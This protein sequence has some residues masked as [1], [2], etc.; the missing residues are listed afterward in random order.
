MDKW[1]YRRVQLLIMAL[2]VGAGAGAAVSFFCGWSKSIGGLTGGMVGLSLLWLWDLRNAAKVMHWLGDESAKVNLPIVFSNP[3]L[4][5]ELFRRAVR[6]LRMRDKQIHYERE[7]LQL[8]LSALQIAP[9]G[10]IL[11]DQHNRVVWGNLSASKFL[12]LV[13]P[14]DYQQQITNL[15]RQ[16]E[17]V[18][19]FDHLQTSAP[20]SL[21]IKW[22]KEHQNSLSLSIV[23]YDDQKKLM[24]LQDITEHERSDQMRRDF[25]A[26]VSHEIRTPL[27][28]LGG[29]IETMQML[30]LE[31]KDKAHFL[32]LMAEQSTRMHH[33]INGLLTL[34]KLEGD[35]VP[36]FDHLVSASI[37][38]DKAKNIAYQLAS[39]THQ[40]EFAMEEGSDAQIAGDESE[41]IGA[42]SN[43]VANAVRYTP[44]GSAIKVAWELQRDG[45]GIFYVQDNGSGI[46]KE[47]L[48]RLSERFYRIDRSRS[49]QTGGTG[50]GLSIVKHTMQRH[51]GS[52]SIE[53]ELGKGS[54]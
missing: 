50:L 3:N 47:H 42:L 53:S 43:L 52:L 40:L 12:G 2:L 41:L 45:S 8:I 48:S 19:Y 20:H 11:L 51:G 22:G 33:L 30:P 31:E 7:Q 35:P 28:V 13:F 36:G 34:A 26:N 38:M 5:G 44:H 23:S 1:F 32:D 15:V 37:L 14:K 54:K 21:K 9:V 39:E 16:P 10:L 49:R 46:A 29:F 24:M 25:V 6:L 18:R 27:T 17:V 4:W